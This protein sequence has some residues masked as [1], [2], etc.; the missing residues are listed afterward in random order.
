M[1]GM[2]RQEKKLE[3][4]K[5]S[6]HQLQHQALRKE[7]LAIESNIKLQEAQKHAL[8]EKMAQASNSPSS[9][10]P[11]SGQK[12]SALELATS[13][14]ALKQVEQSLT[15]MEE[16]WLEISQTLEGLMASSNN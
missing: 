14:K 13:G 7:L 8:L 1:K 2:S 3:S 16:Q 4:Q 6:S 15:Q 12:N 5:K 9:T 11:S 10:S